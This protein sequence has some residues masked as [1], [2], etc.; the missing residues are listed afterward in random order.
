VDVVLALL[1]IAGGVIGA[2]VGAQIG[3]RLRPELLRLLLALL[4]LG[5]GGQLALTLLL[6]PEEV[7]TLD[8]D[9]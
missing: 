4:V 6:P 9:G 8:T 5:V 2:Q 7:F 1:L 3:T